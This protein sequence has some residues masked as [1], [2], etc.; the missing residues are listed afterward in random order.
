MHAG[1]ALQGLQVSRHFSFK[2][3][4]MLL[5]C[6]CPQAYRITEEMALKISYA[7]ALVQQI[8]DIVIDFFVTF[9]LQLRKEMTCALAR[10]RP[11]SCQ[12]ACREYAG[13]QSPIQF[14]E[15]LFRA[16]CSQI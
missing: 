1:A 16:G 14:A 3:L 9:C 12:R 8:Y 7:N 10:S 5:T 15:N 11:Q 6:T 13:I 4:R 2:N